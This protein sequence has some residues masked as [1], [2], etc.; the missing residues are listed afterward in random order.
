MIKIE[1]LFIAI[2]IVIVLVLGLYADTNYKESKQKDIVIEQY[3]KDSV[4]YK[5]QI[6]SLTI[7]KDAKQEILRNM[8]DSDAVALFYKLLSDK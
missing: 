6:D 4:K 7:K 1:R 3:K 2:L 5:F 8:S